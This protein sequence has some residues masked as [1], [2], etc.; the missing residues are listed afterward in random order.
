M[1]PI[2]YLLTRFFDIP[3]IMP[4][5][6]R[7]AFIMVG[8]SAILIFLCLF[9][10]N[11]LN[12]KGRSEEKQWSNICGTLMSRMTSLMP[13]YQRTLLSYNESLGS[14]W[15]NKTDTIFQQVSSKTKEKAEWD[16]CMR[17]AGHEDREA[18]LRE[19]LKTLLGDS[20]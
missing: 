12:I 13:M 16:Y 15:M 14:N 6:L 19:Q 17:D 5:D 20:S 3:N 4:S 18:L 8:I 11:L 7:P 1:D 9:K 10:K 2:E